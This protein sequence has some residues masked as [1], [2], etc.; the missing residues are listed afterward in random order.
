MPAGLPGFQKLSGWYGDR[1][2][3]FS[4][5]ALLAFLCAG[6][7]AP[8]SLAVDFNRD[9]RPILSD[10]CFA[11]HGPDAKARKGGLRLDAR[12]DALAH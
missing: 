9:I 3:N 4:I 8:A 10:K 11:C 1:R 12:E 2:M 6:A 7:V 5:R